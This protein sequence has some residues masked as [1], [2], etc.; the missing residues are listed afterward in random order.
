MP[1]ETLIYKA[2]GGVDGFS[3]FGVG[4]GEHYWRETDY[5]EYFTLHCKG[6]VDTKARSLPLLLVTT[7]TGGNFPEELAPATRA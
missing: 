7:A 2:P 5:G 6:H 3:R 1:N 4:Y